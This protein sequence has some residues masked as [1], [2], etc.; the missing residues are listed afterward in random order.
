MW[1]NVV[2]QQVFFTAENFILHEV[3]ITLWG[4]EEEMPV[5]FNSLSNYTTENAGAKSV[6]TKNSRQWEGVTEC[7]V[8]RVGRR[9]TIITIFDNEHRNYVLG[10]PPMGLPTRKQ[11]KWSDGILVTSCLEQETKSNVENAMNACAECI[12]MPYNTD[13]DS[14][15]EYWPSGLPGGMSSH[16]TLHPLKL[17]HTPACVKTQCLW[18]DAK[19]GAQLKRIRLW[20]LPHT[21]LMLTSASCCRHMQQESACSFSVRQDSGISTQ[22]TAPVY[23]ITGWRHVTN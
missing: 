3:T 17:G 2:E 7:N 10:Q 8:D 12:Q 9:H 5:Y 21:G 13:C 16:Y 18:H 19:K 14:C 4:N 22:R 6:V 20:K 11:N 1:T 23:V 15:S